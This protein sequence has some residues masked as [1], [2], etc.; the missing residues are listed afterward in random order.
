M[1][2][3]GVV[4]LARQRVFCNELRVAYPHGC[5]SEGI[6]LAF[7]DIL[8]WLF[9]LQAC[10]LIIHLSFHSPQTGLVTNDVSIFFKQNSFVL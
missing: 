5:Y 2:H 4:I 6:K 8:A 9:I 10:F 7:P 3:S 1:V